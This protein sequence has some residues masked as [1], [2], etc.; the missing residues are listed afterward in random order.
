MEDNDGFTVVLSKRA[1]QKQKRAK[2]LE[3]IKHF[4][5]FELPRG[6]RLFDLQIGLRLTK[7]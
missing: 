4:P 7:R 2:K 1:L 5:F 3:L 6:R